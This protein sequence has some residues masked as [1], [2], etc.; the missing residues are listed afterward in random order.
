MCELMGMSSN[1]LTNVN[2]SLTTLAKRGEYP[3]L[4][5]DGW[6]VAF[7]ENGGDVRLIK[8]AGEAKNSPWVEFI[9]SQEIR[10]QVIIAH[11]RKST[12]GEVSYRNTHPFIR[13]LN[14]RMH[15]FAHN[16]TLQ[17]LKGNPHYKTLNYI[18]V[19]N[20]DSELAFCVLMEK[21]KVLWGEYTSN[22]PIEKRLEI[23]KGFCAEMRELGP[24]NFLYTDGDTL[25]A[26]GHHRH[27]PVTDKIEWPGL[28]YLHCS[29]DLKGLEN[30]AKS[31]ISLTGAGHVATLFASVPL[32]E[33]DWRPME[34]GEVL[35]VTLGVR[36]L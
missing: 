32:S 16:G 31:G 14:G 29:D 28:N 9:K 13:E 18:P 34:E 25:F 8:D 24:S 20:T 35:A 15:T 21:M 36:D 19:G 22:P 6:G 10:S 7:Y 17:T 26:H 30:S 2:L 27:N 1:Q 3:R 5:G 11:I 12:M 23:F 33:G 4:H